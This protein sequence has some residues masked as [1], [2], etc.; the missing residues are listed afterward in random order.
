MTT[1]WGL[2]FAGAGSLC[3]PSASSRPR[4]ARRRT[5]SRR[6]R[7]PRVWHRWKW[8]LLA[9]VVAPV[10]GP[11]GVVAAGLL[12]LAFRQEWRDRRRST[13]AVVSGERMATVMRTMVAELRA[14]A[15]PVSA[16]EATAEVVPEL[17][18]ELRA[19][20]SSARLDGELRSASLPELADVWALARK[21]GLPMAVV[22]DAARRDVEAGL[23]F[24]RRLRAKMAGPRASAAVL[25]G[26][27]A[28]CVVL[29]QSMGADP[30][31]VL[32]A[33]VPGQLLLIAGCALIWAGTSWCRA[34]LGKAGFR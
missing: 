32:T 16:A 6:V 22:L 28:V 1:A 15:H 27:P 30:L 7:L 5:R 9:V 26:L 8:L 19:L 24:A 23:S 33:T 4:I 21:Y 11:G 18:G 34:L 29:G 3:W 25:T 20:A 17:A 12:T 14:G 10:A 13:A 2:I 31:H